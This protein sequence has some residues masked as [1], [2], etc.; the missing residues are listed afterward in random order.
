MSTC[1]IGIGSNMGNRR[2]NLVAALELIGRLPGTV[3]RRV[4][5]F[6]DTTPVGGPPGQHQFLNAAAEVETILRPQLLLDRLLDVEVRLGRARSEFW[7]PRPIDLDILLFD[8]MEVN[9]PELTLPHP[10]M[11]FRRFVLEPLVE[12]APDIVHPAGWTIRQRWGQLNSWPHYLAITGPMGVG[13][14]TI[15][16]RIAAQL[17]ADLIEEQFDSA[18]LGRLY[19]GDTLQADTVQRGFLA[20]RCEL[21]DTRRWQGTRPEWIISDFWFAQSIAYSDVL[22][23]ADAREK[24][25]SEVCRAASGVLE[26]TLVVWLDAPPAELAA[27]VHARG[28]PF[29]APIEEEFLA[30]LQAAFGKMFDGSSATPLYRPRCSGLQELTKELLLVAQAISG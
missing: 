7:G 26:P 4:S 5:R 3:V 12:I 28:R 11:H 17:H 20:S 2:A 6:V 16:Q 27:R 8:N 19:G 1:F 30:R 24:H 29:E 10:R 9:E 21:L 25:R 13:K 14:T 18:Q 15:A 23:D 22:C